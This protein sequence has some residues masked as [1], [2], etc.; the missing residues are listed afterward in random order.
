MGILLQDEDAEVRHA[1]TNFSSI[2][3]RSPF[4]PED[5]VINTQLGIENIVYFGLAH[6]TEVME[7]FVPVQTTL[8]TTLIRFD[9]DNTGNKFKTLF[10]R[11]DGINV[12]EEPV[13]ILLTY[14]SCIRQQCK[15]ENLDL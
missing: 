7:M 11:G 1:A 9:A 14:F 4:L 5:A 10:K 15:N 8:N 6:L 2:I 13:H 12:Y 3:K